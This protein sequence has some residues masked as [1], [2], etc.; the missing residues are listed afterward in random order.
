MKKLITLL[1]AATVCTVTANAQ[2]NVNI[3]IGT[4]P[5]W[6]PVGYDHV[7]YYY[8]PDADVYYYV[9][10]RV[11]I[12]KNGNSWTRVRTLPAS[13]RNIDFYTA[14]KVV[15]NNV[16]KPYLNHAKYQKEYA[17]FKGR[18]DQTPIRDSKEEKYFENK[19]HP[20][21]AQWVKDHPNEN[22][23]NKGN[24]GKKGNNGN[25]GRGNGRH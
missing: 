14:H 16:D 6:G 17:G 5:V 15:I 10:D 19:K 1:I 20:Q 18:H 25:N 4:Q 11:Y 24:S 12:Y 22:K 3:N 21:H 23:G 2:V 7:D 13:Y 9:P 8:I